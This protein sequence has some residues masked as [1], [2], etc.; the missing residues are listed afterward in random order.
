MAEKRF[1]TLGPGVEEI[2]LA[3]AEDPSERNACSS[4]KV[5]LKTVAKF[6]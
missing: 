4:P 5:C 3:R 2:T 6:E 1:I